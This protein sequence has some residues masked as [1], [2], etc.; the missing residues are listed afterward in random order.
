MQKILISF[1]LVCGIFTAFFAHAQGSAIIS[2]TVPDVGQGSYPQ[3]NIAVDKTEEFQMRYGSHSV[4][5]VIT[6]ELVM[7]SFLLFLLL[8]LTIIFLEVD[9][10]RIHEGIK[11]DVHSKK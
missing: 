10:Y 3:Q 5:D 9:E 1:L 6:S 8:I 2:A 11:L 4:S 7:W